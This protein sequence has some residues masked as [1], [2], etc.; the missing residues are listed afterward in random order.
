MEY[1]ELYKFLC[2]I[3]S[4]HFHRVSPDSNGTICFCVMGLALFPRDKG[5]NQ[6]YQIVNG[7]GRTFRRFALIGI[8]LINPYVALKNTQIHKVLYHMS[9]IVE[10]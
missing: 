2:R 8:F 5:P 6:G 10:G 4:G 1:S 9:L 3:K 7:G